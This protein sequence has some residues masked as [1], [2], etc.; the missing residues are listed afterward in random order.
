MSAPAGP[1][2]LRAMDLRAAVR[3]LQR[4]SPWV[5]DAGLAVGLAAIALTEIARDAPCPCVTASDAW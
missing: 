4:L 3:R 1:A 5:V 2:T